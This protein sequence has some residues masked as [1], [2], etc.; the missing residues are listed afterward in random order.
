MTATSGELRLL[1]LHCLLY[2][3]AEV[4]RYIRGRLTRQ[5]ELL[6]QKIRLPT[7]RDGLHVSRISYKDFNLRAD[8][9]IHGR[10]LSF[11]L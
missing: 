1:L 5:R 2:E 11:D 7:K 10:A 4:M 9:E 6:P 3:P 8:D